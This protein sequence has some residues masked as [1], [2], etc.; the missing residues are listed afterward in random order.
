MSHSKCNCTP[1][2]P[3]PLTDCGVNVDKIIACK[4]PHC[5]RALVPWVVV[6]ILSLL[7]IALAILFL[8]DK[9]EIRYKEQ[10]PN[11][12][13]VRVEA[14]ALSGILAESTAI[15]WSL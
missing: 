11:F 9:I 4:D 14:E 7:G 10:N 15:R 2:P 3:P 6:S 5:T 1:P 8:K 13:S 12:P